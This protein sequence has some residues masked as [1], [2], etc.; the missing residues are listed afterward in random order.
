MTHDNFDSRNDSKN[1]P[2]SPAS[3][4]TADEEQLIEPLD[5]ATGQS[6]EASQVEKP[7]SQLLR[8]LISA[9]FLVLF[10]YD[11][12]KGLDSIIVLTRFTELDIIQWGILLSAVV[13]PFII[14]ALTCWLMWKQSRSKM[15]LALFV[16]W[17]VSAMTFLDLQ[18]LISVTFL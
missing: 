18:S 3:S 7:K 2:A 12:W 17:A 9:V 14:W 8:F 13:L 5:T 16:A 10:A 6:P 15:A 11:M 1:L 4:G